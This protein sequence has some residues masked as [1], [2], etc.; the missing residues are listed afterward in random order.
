VICEKVIVRK[1]FAGVRAVRA[2]CRA[3]QCKNDRLCLHFFTV[4]FQTAPFSKLHDCTI[5]CKRGELDSHP[6]AVFSCAPL[7]CRSPKLSRALLKVSLLALLVDP[8]V[9]A[10]VVSPCPPGERTV[11]VCLAH[12]DVAPN[13]TSVTAITPLT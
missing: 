13:G 12:S 3:V 5:P 1:L 7:K 9:Q 6:G 10:G 2:C 8:L 4:Y 11:S